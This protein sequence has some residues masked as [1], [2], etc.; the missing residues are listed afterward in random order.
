MDLTLAEKFILLAH[1]PEKSRY[2]VPDQM[3]D[4][5]LIGSIFMDLAADNRIKIHDGKLVVR[6]TSTELPAVYEEVLRKVAGS[7]K[8]RR[9]KAW[10]SRF[11]QR[12]GKYRKKVLELLERNRLIR[13]EHK[14]FLFIPYM[15]S[16]LIKPGDRQM[17]IDELHNAVKHI[18]EADTNQKMLLSIIHACKMHQVICRNKPEI[19]EF[20]EILKT[21]VHSDEIAQGVGRVLRE[22]QAALVIA[23]PASAIAAATTSH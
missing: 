17:I 20:R 3:R 23:V 7:S 12:S 6:N 22:M 18:K 13:I 10:I 2:V 9:V 19:K 21:L 16:T 5:G 4:V 8:K 15:R 11:A 14:H 1:H